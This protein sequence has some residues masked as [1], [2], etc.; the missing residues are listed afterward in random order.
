MA[1]RPLLFTTVFRPL[2]GARRRQTDATIQDMLKLNKPKI[3]RMPANH[4]RFV[5]VHDA[6]HASVAG[7]ASQQAH[8]IFAVHNNVTEQKGPVSILSW[9]KKRFKSVPQQFGGRD[10]QHGDMHGAVG[11]DENLVEADDVSRLQ[12]GKLRGCSGQSLYVNR[13]ATCHRA[14]HCQVTGN[15]KRSG[16]E[17]DRRTVPNRRR[18]HEA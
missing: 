9:S 18:P 5:R 13:R 7:G 4:R 1:G 2:R 17:V 16:L 8:V 10:K 6:T 15:G 11:L 3:R 12:F 14:C